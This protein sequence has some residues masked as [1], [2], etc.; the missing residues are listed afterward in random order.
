[1]SNSGPTRTGVQVALAGEQEFDHGTISHGIVIVDDSGTEIGRETV[2]VAGLSL[3]VVQF[4]DLADGRRVSDP[5]L[6]TTFLT[7]QRDITRAELEDDL[8]ELVSGDDLR[9]DD[10]D[11]ADPPWSEFV[12][13]LARAGIATDEPALLALPFVVELDDAVRR[14]LEEQ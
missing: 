10:P 14:A 2:S 1:M 12:E 13:L 3:H 7:V 4:V 11:C 5:E 9:E 8:R 6:G